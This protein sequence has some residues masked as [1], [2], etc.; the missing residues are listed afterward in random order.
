MQSLMIETIIFLRYAMRM[1]LI[2][3]DTRLLL[4]MDIFSVWIEFHLL[5]R[6]LTMTM[7]HQ[8]SFYNTVSKT[9][10]IN[11][12]S[13]HQRKLSPSSFPRLAMMFGL[14]I[15]E[16]TT[17][18][19][20]TLLSTQNKKSSGNLTLRRWVSTMFLQWSTLFLKRPR[21]RIRLESLQLILAI[22][23]VRLNSLLGHL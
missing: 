4:K 17:T 13:T 7:R 15:I 3:D 11:G 22:Q 8:S 16:A 5:E 2:L 6:K 12:S 10:Q 14:E 23:R 21:V 19:K 1:V 20:F 9:P 18:L